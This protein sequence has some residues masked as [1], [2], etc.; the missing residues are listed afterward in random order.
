MMAEAPFKPKDVVVVI[1]GGP[2]MTVTQ[3]AEDQLGVMTVWCTWFDKNK[4]MNGT[5]PA[6]ALKIYEGD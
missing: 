6:A 5:F 2:V 3:C 1:S 4:P